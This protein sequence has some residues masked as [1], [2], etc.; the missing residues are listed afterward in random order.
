MIF[1]PQR[2]RKVLYGPA[3]RHLG[4][5]F[6]ALAHQK[7]GPI[8]EADLMPD[9]V[10]RCIALPPKPPGASVIGF[11]KGK[12]SMAIARPRCDRERNFTGEHFGARG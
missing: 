1:V 3:R 8:L 4:A 5:I 12:S 9:H 11:L 6:P 10:P 2:R 7:E